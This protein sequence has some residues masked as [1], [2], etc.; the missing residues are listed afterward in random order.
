MDFSEKIGHLIVRIGFPGYGKQEFLPYFKFD[1]M[2]GRV[3]FIVML[4][5]M[6]IQ[7]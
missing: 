1:P 5:S 3:K 4:A 6:A 7:G 2:F